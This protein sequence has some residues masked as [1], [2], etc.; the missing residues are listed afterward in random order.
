MSDENTEEVKAEVSE[1]KRLCHL[2]LDSKTADNW[3]HYRE[4]KRAA[5]K[6]VTAVKAAHYDDLSNK[7]DSRDG[8]RFI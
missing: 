5:K 4:A 6:A 8:E 3:L 7:L 1:K 2:F